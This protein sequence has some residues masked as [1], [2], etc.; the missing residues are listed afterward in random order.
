MYDIPF[1]KREPRTFPASPPVEQKVFRTIG[2]STPLNPQVFNARMTQSGLSRPVALK[3]NAKRIDSR[4]SQLDRNKVNAFNEHGSRLGNNLTFSSSLSASTRHGFL[5]INED[6]FFISK[7]AEN[8]GHLPDPKE[9]YTTSNLNDD[10]SKESKRQKFDLMERHIADKR[11]HMEEQK[12]IVDNAEKA[13]RSK[14]EGRWEKIRQDRSDYMDSLK[15]RERLEKMKYC[16]F[17]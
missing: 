16:Q 8:S 3:T 11:E 17:D 15:K 10:I 12:M 6:T 4:L 9:M 2:Y 5:P 13:I 14:E 1:G 7:P